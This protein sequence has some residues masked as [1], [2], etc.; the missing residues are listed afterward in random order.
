MRDM[1]FQGLYMIVVLQDGLHADGLARHIQA[2]HSLYYEGR[3]LEDIDETWLFKNT[4]LV[5]K[6]KCKAHSMGNG[7]KWG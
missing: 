2:Y 4:D 3:V 6:C 7:I 1:D 5:S